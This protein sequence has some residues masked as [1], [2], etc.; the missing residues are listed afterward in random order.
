[1]RIKSRLQ[2]LEQ[3]KGKTSFFISDIVHIDKDIAVWNGVQHN[4]YELF[5]MYPHLLDNHCIHIIRK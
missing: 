3:Q 2:K 1:M 5:K 4:K